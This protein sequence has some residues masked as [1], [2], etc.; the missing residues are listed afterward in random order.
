MENCVFCERK[1]SGPVYIADCGR[2]MHTSCM[3]LK[4]KNKYFG[5]EHAAA[6]SGCSSGCG[7]GSGSGSG[8]VRDGRCLCRSEL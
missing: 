4:I 3:A 6:G 2:A 8:C 5:R 7:S 1:L